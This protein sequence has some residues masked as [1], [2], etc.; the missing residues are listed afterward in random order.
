M[1]GWLLLDYGQ[2]LCTAPPADEWA[3]LAAAAEHSD[4]DSFGRLYW[5]H[6]VAY[7]RGDLTPAGYWQ[8]VA[9]SGDL[10][11]L[12]RLD[13]AIWMHPHQPSVD[14]ARRAA[15]RGWQLAL[16]SNAPEDV[17]A[18]IDA[19]DW[20]QFI[21]HRFFSCRIGEVKPEPQSYRQAILFLGTT[22]GDVVFM[23]DRAANVQAASELGIRAELYEGPE[24][25]DRL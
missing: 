14:A 9:P 10:V 13:V 18:A 16:L 19:L 11:R 2:V 23:D 25:M 12:R 1:A 4:L 17:A 22:A 20:M 7:D 5:R 21:G 24:Q 15:G 8:L 3:A 6:R